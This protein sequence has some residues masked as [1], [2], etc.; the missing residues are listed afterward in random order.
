MNTTIAQY[1]APAVCDNALELGGPAGAQIINGRWVA[2][3]DEVASEMAK[4]QAKL[5]S[6]GHPLAKLPGVLAPH[7]GAR[8][9]KGWKRGLEETFQALGRGDAIKVAAVLAHTTAFKEVSSVLDMAQALSEHFTLDFT[10]IVAH[11]EDLARPTAD[12]VFQTIATALKHLV[13]S[14]VRSGK[15]FPITRELIH[16]HSS[17]VQAREEIWNQ[18]QGTPCVEDLQWLVPFYGRQNSYRPQGMEQAYHDLTMRRGVGLL[19][20]KIDPAFALLTELKERLSRCYRCPCPALNVKTP[21]NKPG[22]YDADQ[23]PEALL[24]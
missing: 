3:P 21:G 18:T 5:D 8:S 11:W 1:T 6:A 12:E 22:E 10:L 7:L 16:R 19:I 23:L 17:F 24:V 9:S 4:L 2:I 13:K 15:L 20:E 14:R